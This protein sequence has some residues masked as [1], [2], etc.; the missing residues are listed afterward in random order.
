MRR[1]WKPPIFEL[2]EQAFELCGQAKIPADWV[3]GALGYIS[4]LFIDA[5]GAS[6]LLDRQG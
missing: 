6:D 4:S 3:L 2:R 5:T 1:S